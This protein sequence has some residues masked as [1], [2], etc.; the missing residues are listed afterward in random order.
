VAGSKK[1]LHIKH[2]LIIYEVDKCDL[3][4]SATA[5]I[6]AYQSAIISPVYFI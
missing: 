5:W 6:T 2:E 1:S 4:M 3:L